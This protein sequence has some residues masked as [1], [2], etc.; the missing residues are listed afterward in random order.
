MDDRTAS[1]SAGAGGGPRPHAPVVVGLGEALWDVFDDQALFGGA[2]ANFACHAAAMGAQACM[3]S[4]VGSDELGERALT[5]LRSCGVDV[6]AVARLDNVPTGTVRVSLDP[7]GVP[8]Y[9]IIRGVAWDRIPWSPAVETLAG[10]ADAVCFGSLAQREDQSRRTIHRF[11]QATPPTCLRVFDVNLR[12]EFFSR[13]IIER[14]LACSSVLKLN[15]EELPV[16]ADLLGLKATDE[17]GRIDQLLDRFDLQWVVL[18]LGE[19]GATVA[20]RNVRAS[21]RPQPVQVR[22]T[23]GAG[24]AFTAVITMGLLAGCVLNALVAHA[25]RVAAYVCSQSGAVPPLPGD[26]RRLP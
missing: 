5:S 15:D 4:A 13:D 8:R 2:P 11:L 9:T 25:C 26:L 3:V 7:R 24:D 12:Q 19:R 14:S 22:D 10:R 23:V 17:G 20:R 18:T 21:A 16:L 6:A 1:L